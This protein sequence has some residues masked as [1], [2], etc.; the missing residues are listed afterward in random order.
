MGNFSRRDF[1][2]Q[3]CV[4]L[5]AGAAGLILASDV[6]PTEASGGLGAYEQYALAGAQPKAKGG[7][8]A[9]VNPPRRNWALTEDNILGPFHRPGAPFRAKITPPAEPGTLVVISGRVYGHD[10]R[11][12]LANAVLDIWQANAQGRYDNDD[13]DR[14]PA[15]NV[16]RNR[17]RIITDE[18]GYYEFES[19]KPAPY[20]IGPQAWRP[21]HI[22]Y[23][24]RHT[25]YRDLITQLYFRG[26]EHQ[27]ADA[28]I[29]QS[30][31]IDLREQRTA[32]NAVFKTGTFDIILAAA[33]RGGPGN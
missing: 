26:D 13:P 16:F 9:N 5:S 23:W 30:L 31:I 17:A 7:N 32:S 25:G 28:W 27:R 18:N 29:K 14:P 8:P 3:S 20:R 1:V 19:I 15:A 12:P 10:T 4:G 22:H 24:I 11:R 2:R 33:P 6:P 21:S